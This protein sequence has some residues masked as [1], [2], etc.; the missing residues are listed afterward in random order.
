M[1]VARG[2]TPAES[3][4]NGLT[5]ATL[6]T[7]TRNP[8]GQAFG[9]GLSIVQTNG[10]DVVEQGGA[11]FQM[12]HGYVW[13]SD[14]AESDICHIYC[15]LKGV[16]P[17]L[18]QTAQNDGPLGRHRRAVVQSSGLGQVLQPKLKR[19]LKNSISISVTWSTSVLD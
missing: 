16:G 6:G 15:G 18:I 4:V 3:T 14:V 7:P 12:K 1:S 11:G 17:I 13:P 19:F 2:R 9:E 10:L 5:S 8:A